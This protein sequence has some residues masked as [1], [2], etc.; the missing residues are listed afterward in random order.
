MLL[1]VARPLLRL[2]G[3]DVAAWCAMTGVLLTL[4]FGLFAIL[5]SRWRAAGVEA[6]PIMDAPLRSTSLTEFW[7]RRWN[8]AFRDFSHEFL[9]RPLVKCGLGRWGMLCVFLFSGVV[10]DLVVSV[11]AGGGFGQPTAYFMIQWC[12]LQLER[13][14]IGTFLGLRAG[15]KGRVFTAVCL[16]LPLPLLFHELFR[17]NVVLPMLTDWGV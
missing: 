2:A 16:L 4:H 7:G 15:W 11:P 12:G 5:S 3:A 8:R 1:V 13:S 9:F 10:H 17:M 6:P 14:R